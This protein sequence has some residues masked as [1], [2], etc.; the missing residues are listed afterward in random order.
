MA[1]QRVVTVGVE[2]AADRTRVLQLLR[3][4]R[5]L[6]D[7]AP[8]FADAVEPIG[9]GGWRVTK[10]GAAFD[11]WVDVHPD[12][13]TVDFLRR[14]DSGGEG[15]AFLRVMPRP[16]GGS[17]IS[18]TAP[19]PAGGDPAQVATELRAELLALAGLASTGG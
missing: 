5:R 2:C 9:E 7:W 17:V 19:V 6:P 12:A 3:D 14:L 16:G 13:G 15:G 4:P 8:P 10:G 18:M 11:L 1:E